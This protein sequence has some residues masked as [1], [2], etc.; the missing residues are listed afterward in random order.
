[1]ALLLLAVLTI[2]F[3][4]TDKLNR[5]LLF[6]PAL[7]LLLLAFLRSEFVVP[8]GV[9]VGVAVVL[10]AGHVNK[11]KKLTVAAAAVCLILMFLMS[12]ECSSYVGT[13]ARADS[14][15]GI[16]KEEIDAMDILLEQEDVKGIIAPKQL[17]PYLPVYSSKL[18]TLY[19][20][21]T[22]GNADNLSGNT[23]EIYLEMLKHDFDTENLVEKA[24]EEDCNYIIL[25]TGY[26]YPAVLLEAYDFEK[27]ASA[28]SYDIYKDVR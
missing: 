1:M 14:L 21:P 28:G 9:F 18:R 13:V 2:Y 27:M 7:A 4:E 8:A 3:L 24:R 17:A 20:Y 22:D 23:K 16:P 10:T 6:Y 5:R 26:H 15:Y 25:D 11:R 19:T 12:G